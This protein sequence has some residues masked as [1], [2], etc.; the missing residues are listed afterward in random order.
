MSDRLKASLE[1]LFYQKGIPMQAL[2]LGSMFNIVLTDEK[3]TSYRD[4]QVSDFDL[5]RKIDLQLLDQGIYGKPLNRYSLSTC[6][7]EKEIER[8]LEAFDKVLRLL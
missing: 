7:G 5:R 4:L 3:I 1:A 6:H 2:G 8:T